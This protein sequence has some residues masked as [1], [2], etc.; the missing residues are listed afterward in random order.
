MR[1]PEKGRERIRTHHRGV[2]P[3]SARGRDIHRSAGGI[4]SPPFPVRTPH[5]SYAK[6]KPV[7]ATSLWNQCL[8]RLEAELPEQHFNTWIRPL[9][10]VEDEGFLRLLAPNRYVIDWVS[11]NCADRIGEIV[12][13]LVPPPAPAVIFE[14]GS[15]MT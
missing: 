6:A 9:Q 11:Q 14:I 3:C 12:V 5:P 13:E 8:R 2:N 7:V 15:R 1:G 4:N 10:A